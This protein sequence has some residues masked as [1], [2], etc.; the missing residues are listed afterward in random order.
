MDL[1][2]IPKQFCESVTLGYAE[3]YFAVAMVSGQNVNAYSLTPQHA[4]RLLQ[5][6]TYNIE[7]Y[8]KSFGEIK[9]EWVPGVQSPI[10]MIDLN[11]PK[12]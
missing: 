2:K 4:K 1:S 11:K 7:N 5:Y 6:L 8:E 12:A 9:A 10:Q 3:E